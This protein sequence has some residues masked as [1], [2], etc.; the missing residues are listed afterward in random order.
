VLHIVL[1]CV[2]YDPVCAVT[3]YAEGV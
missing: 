1:W 2:L 3:A